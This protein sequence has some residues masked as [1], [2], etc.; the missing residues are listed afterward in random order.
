[1]DW[2][3]TQFAKVEKEA[4]KAEKRYLG[5]LG[6]VYNGMSGGCQSDCERREKGNT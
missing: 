4:L 2:K 5:G 6:L 3:N 1:M